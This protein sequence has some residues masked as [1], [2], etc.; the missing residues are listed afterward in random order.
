MS[1]KNLLYLLNMDY[2]NFEA[3][4]S[5]K[6]NDLTI[7]MINPTLTPEIYSQKCSLLRR[8]IMLNLMSLQGVVSA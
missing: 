1:I 7:M 3:E 8:E 5:D 4:V 6:G 2:I